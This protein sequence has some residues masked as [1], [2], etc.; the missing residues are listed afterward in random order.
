MVPRRRLKCQRL[1][2][3]DRCPRYECSSREAP[4]TGLNTRLRAHVTETLPTRCAYCPEIIRERDRGWL[5]T[6]STVAPCTAGASRILRATNARR[7]DRRRQAVRK[8][9]CAP[10]TRF[11]RAP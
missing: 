9:T 2:T 3:G 4:G 11:W 6:L 8:G 5:R 7:A 10:R 1:F